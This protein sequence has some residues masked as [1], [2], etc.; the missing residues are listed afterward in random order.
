MPA[1]RHADAVR[2]ALAQEG[3]GILRVLFAC[4]REYLPAGHGE[5]LY[6]AVSGSWLLAHDDPRIQRMAECYVQ[7]QKERRGSCVASGSEIA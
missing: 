6:D 5:L 3:D 2:F 4:E 1:D 7:A